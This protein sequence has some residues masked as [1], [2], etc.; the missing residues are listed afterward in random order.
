MGK[1]LNV[2]GEVGY[3]G[4]GHKL[5]EGLIWTK[6]RLYT[7]DAEGWLKE[8]DKLDLVTKNRKE[9]ETKI[10]EYSWDKFGVK[11]RDRR[12]VKTKSI[13]GF[14]DLPQWPELEKHEFVFPT[15]ERKCGV[16]GIPYYACLPWCPACSIPKPIEAN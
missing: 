8:V 14:G 10:R 4:S 12:I 5:G 11:L 7:T 3:T 16:C 15:R 6:T 9:A 13:F 2:F 1:Y